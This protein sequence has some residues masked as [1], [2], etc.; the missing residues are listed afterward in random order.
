MKKTLT[1]P[2]RNEYPRPQF[3]RRE[4]VNLNGEWTCELDISRSGDWRNLKD[5]KG[6]RRK[7]IVPFCPES[8]LSGIGFTDFIEMIWYHKK[9][10]IPAKWKGKLILLHFGGVDYES[11]IYINGQEIGRHTGGCSPFTLDIS[12]FVSAGKSH[13]LIVQA[14]DENRNGLQPMG[15]QNPWYDSRGCLYT[16]TTGIWQTVWMEAVDP[17]A[18]KS[19][20]IIPD[21]DNGSFTFLPEFYQ[22]GR[23]LD[24]NISLRD[25]RKKVAAACIAAGNH[26]AATIKLSKPKEWNP[27]S[28][29][30]YNMKLTL[31][32]SRGRVIDEVET[33]GGLRKFHIEGN[34]FYLNNQPVFLR[35]VLDQ[36]FYADSLW[37]APSDRDLKRDIELA[38]KAGFNGARLHQKIFDERYHYW[39]D[40]L[41]YLTWGEFPDWG[42]SFWQHFRPTNPDYQRSFRN[43]FAE[44]GAVVERDRNHPSIITWTPL[45][46]T[47]NIFDLG[48]HRRFV[49]DLYDFT[50]R[51]DPTRPVHDTSG[52]THAK[53]DIWSVHLYRL[54]QKSFEE[55]L[56][57]EPVCMNF[58]KDEENA[59][60]GQPFVIAEYGGLRYLPEGRKPFASN[61]WGYNKQQISAEECV[62]QITGLTLSIVKNPRCAG[63]CYTQLTDVEQE[64]NGLYFYAERTPKFD[65]KMIRKCFS[66]KPD[67]SRF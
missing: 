3:K 30:L 15:K 31:T 7:I 54:D 44:W 57:E 18:L 60:R 17:H 67:W 62:K 52:Y 16:R 32:D 1:I 24:L 13:D 40:R 29:F 2:P 45:N 39:A 20:R 50:K 27:E 33:Y 5:K 49:S 63:Y 4:W 25:G 41:G 11:T 26:A 34:R 51:L 56:N 66:A 22:D 43:F 35:F 53:T 46:E 10:N 55:H 59:Y 64:E 37:T 6:F 47:C 65:M 38:M 48:E 8:K 23:G 42:L 61:S 28:P 36:G 19:C 58:R 21:F 12:R 9:L 14:R